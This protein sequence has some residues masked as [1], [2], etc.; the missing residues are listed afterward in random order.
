[1]K[2]PLI[3]P[4]C[5]GAL[6]KSESGLVCPFG[7]RFDRAAKGYVHLLPGNRALHGDNAE[8]IA[9]RRRFL[10]SGAYEPLSRAISEALGK[11]VPETGAVLDAG[12]G[13]GYYTARLA[14]EHPEMRIYGVDLSRDAIRAAASRP[15]LKGQR[16]E[17]YVAGVYA[18]PFANGSFDA[19]ASV[20]SPFAGDEFRRTL[21]SGGILLSVI[22]GARHLIEL[23]GVLY[24]TPYEN[25]VSDYAVEGFSF[26]EKIELRERILL[27]TPEQIHDLFAMTPYYH[28]TPRSGHE[29]L[30]ALSSLECETSFEILVYRR[31]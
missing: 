23:K 14:E 12:C 10:E 16:V 5:K 8:M 29:R 24:D 17:L 6:M 2:N 28:R 22:P 3:C 27:K 25:T 4:V 13:E 26:L 20:F 15:P 18:L 1:M 9:A 11:H 21:K 19:I 7:H 31:L 30:A